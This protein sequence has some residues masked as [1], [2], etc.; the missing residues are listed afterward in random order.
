MIEIHELSVRRETSERVSA[1]VHGTGLARWKYRR[2]T[3]VLLVHGFNTTQ[4]EALDGYRELI[5]HL[6]LI[7][8][9]SVDI[10]FFAFH[11]PGDARDAGGLLNVAGFPSRVVSADHSGS[12]LSKLLAENHNDDIILIAHSLGSR[13][14]LAALGLLVEQQATT[15][16]IP[17]TVLMAAAVTERECALGGDFHT[18]Y[19]ST[20]YTVLYSP[21]DLVLRL[22]FRVGQPVFSKSSAAQAVGLHGR[23]SE[24]WDDRRNTGLGHSGYWASMDA[25]RATMDALGAPR[26][27]IPI[28]RRQTIASRG[29][30]VRSTPKRHIQS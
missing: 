20:R 26:K 3:K 23:P 12:H 27:A 17:H 8:N 10:D 6:N 2:R 21:R 25:A 19:P 29:L 13:V 30:A 22:A 5:E 11:W 28:T 15:T 4:A 18:P 16:P 9:L 7:S 14:V 24:R 1:D